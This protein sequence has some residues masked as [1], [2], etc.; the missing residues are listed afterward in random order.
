MNKREYLRS[1]GF[2]VGERGRFN[3]AMIS[4]INK[5]EGTFDE[6]IPGKSSKSTKHV[7]YAK[8]EKTEVQRMARTL[9]GKTAEG[10]K[11][12]FITC[13]SCHNHMIYC[14]CP[15]GVMAPKIVTHSDDTLVFVP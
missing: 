10:Y 15:Q 5:Y 8:Q 14:Q 7:V 11:V 4:A 2:N 1:L 3:E 9:F 6:V 12:G 13:S